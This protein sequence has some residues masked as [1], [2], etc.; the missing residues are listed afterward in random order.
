MLL[1]SSDRDCRSTGS[2]LYSRYVFPGKLR[3]L[4]LQSCLEYT[5]A[6]PFNI[7]YR[8]AH[9]FRYNDMVFENCDARIPHKGASGTVS[10]G[11]KILIR[12]CKNTV[13]KV[14]GARRQ[15]DSCS[16]GW[17]QQECVA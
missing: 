14:T 17:Q 9:T 6:D 13:L 3:L 12:E 4:S 7:A 8:H 10:T 11:A 2:T 15:S 1:L 16:V 5:H